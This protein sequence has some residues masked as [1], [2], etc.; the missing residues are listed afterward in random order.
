MTLSTLGPIPSFEFV[1]VIGGGGGFCGSIAPLV[2]P[3]ICR[4]GGGGSIGTG[5]RVPLKKPEGAVGTC[6]EVGS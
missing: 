4:G 2:M 6:W 5:G 3:S 1:W